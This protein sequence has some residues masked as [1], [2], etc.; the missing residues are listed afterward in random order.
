[1]NTSKYNIKKANIS[2]R[3][4]IIYLSKR[5]REHISIMKGED[6]VLDI[7]IPHEIRIVSLKTWGNQITK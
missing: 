7:S 1:M 3:G 4:T 2:G 6:V 5:E